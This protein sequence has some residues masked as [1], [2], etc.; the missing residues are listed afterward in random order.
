VH[1]FFISK[2][3]IAI[4]TFHYYFLVFPIP[5]DGR[6][7]IFKLV[8]S[9]ITPL[10]KLSKKQAKMKFLLLQTIKKY[11]RFIIWHFVEKFSAFSISISIV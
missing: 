5:K 11:L 9:F 4:K 7:S 6:K 8:V 2:P 10:T 1:L 3:S